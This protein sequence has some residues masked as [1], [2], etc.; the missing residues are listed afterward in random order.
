VNSKKVRSGKPQEILNSKQLRENQIGYVV[1]TLGNNLEWLAHS[2][3]SLRLSSKDCKIVIVT[4]SRTEPL[5]Q[6]AEKYSTVLVEEETRGVYPALNQGVA[7]LESLGA[8]YFAFL[9]DDDVL[10]PGSTSNLLKEFQDPTVAVAY[11]R[12]WYVD[13]K[14]I[15]KMS[16]SGYPILKILLSWIP[17]IIPNPGTLIRISHFNKIGKY[18]PALKWAG[19]LDLWLRIRKIGKIRFVDTPVALFRWHDESLT[20]GQRRESLKEAS[21]VRSRNSKKIL[22]PFHMIWEPFITLIGEILRKMKWQNKEC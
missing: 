18:D 2:L 1:P 14:L 22:K 8:D 6:L 17:N 5:T 7:L 3:E 12:I 21:L 20:A 15:T 16:N 13:K 11:G 19:D 4:N 9:G 10:I